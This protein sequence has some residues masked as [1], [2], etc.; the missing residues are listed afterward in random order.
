MEIFFFKIVGVLV[1]VINFVFSYFWKIIDKNNWFF[2]VD[3]GL[4]KEN[5]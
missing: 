4:N 5:I 2:F 1:L 3:F